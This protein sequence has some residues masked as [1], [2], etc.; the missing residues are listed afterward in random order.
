MN[1]KKPRIAFL[2]IGGAL[3][4]GRAI[5]VA[6]EF[7]I[8]IAEGVRSF[9]DEIVEASGA[10][11][12]GRRGQLRKYRILAERSR[13]NTKKE[14]SCAVTHQTSL[15]PDMWSMSLTSISDGWLGARRAVRGQSWRRQS[16]R[17][18]RARVA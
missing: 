10:G 5:V 1:A 15:R 7:L 2:L 17:S 9:R 12:A 11:R 14:C 8:E 18:H 3:A 6:A 13:L 4:S 16:C